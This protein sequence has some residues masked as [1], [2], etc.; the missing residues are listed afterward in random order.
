[1]D[2]ISLEVFH[3]PI[4]QDA[5]RISCRGGGLAIYIN[6]T[7][8]ESDD[9]TP[10]FDKD[11]EILNKEPESNPPGE[12]LFVKLAYKTQHANNM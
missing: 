5:Y 10:L 8:R 1:M 11:A 3:E 7:F 6:K 12:F 9:I 4:V 2:D